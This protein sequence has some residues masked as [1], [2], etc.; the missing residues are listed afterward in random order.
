MASGRMLR[1]Q[2]S[3]S[4]QVNDLSLKAALL[5]TWLIP[6]VDDFGRFYGEPRRIKA[7][8]VPMRDDIKIDDIKGALIEMY[9]QKLIILY[10]VDGETYLELSKFETHQQGLHKRT[11]SKFPSPKAASLLDSRKF[12]EIP[13][14]SQKFPLEQ[15]Q[16]QEQEQEKNTLSGKPDDSSFFS[17][18]KTKKSQERAQRREQA[19]EVLAFLNKKTKKSFRPVEANLKPIEARIESG[20][21]LDDC[22][23]VIA[24]K[25]REW[26]FNDDFK[27]HL[28]P[29]TIFRP[30]NFEKY[31]G[32]LEIIP[33]EGDND[34]R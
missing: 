18:Q 11:S 20:V 33:E 1:G 4:M 16:E 30:S 13:G 29:I 10:V 6:H 7:I 25:C 27:K 21:S 5:F 12:P 28:N 34:V 9:D 24:L 8:V 2:I 22:R 3:V 32:Q 14:N 19:K 17:D 26:L 31:L 23:S 15:E